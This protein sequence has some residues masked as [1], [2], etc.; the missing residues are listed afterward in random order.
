[1][2]FLPQVCPPNLCPHLP[3]STQQLLS[4][5]T[6]P[7]GSLDA[8]LAPLGQDQ[9]P[10]ATRPSPLPIQQQS[11]TDHFAACPSPV[12][13]T[14]SA[15]HGTEEGQPKASKAPSFSRDKH[16]LFDKSLKMLVLLTALWLPER[17][18]GAQASASP[19]L[20]TQPAAWGCF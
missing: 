7:C 9:P 12:V 3:A 17:W 1:M 8:W 18:K 2:P 4:H 14:P 19:W 20:P 6:D 13:H 15:G 5:R 16:K 11:S 10:L